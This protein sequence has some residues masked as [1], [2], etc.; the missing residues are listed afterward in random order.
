MATKSTTRGS[1][2]PQ[3]TAMQHLPRKD[4][5]RMAF[6]LLSHSSLKALFGTQVIDEYRL[7]RVALTSTTKNTTKLF[8][9]LAESVYYNKGARLCRQERWN[10]MTR[11][12]LE[13]EVL[14]K[15]MVDELEVENS[16]FRLRAMLAGAMLK[17][18]EEKRLENEGKLK[19]GVMLAGAISR[20]KNENSNKVFPQTPLSTSSFE[21]MSFLNILAEAK[22]NTPPIK[23]KSTPKPLTAPKPA[24][25]SIKVATSASTTS[26]SPKTFKPV[27]KKLASTST[28]IA[29]AKPDATDRT[30]SRVTNPV[31]ERSPIG[32]Q[33]ANTPVN[34]TA[35]VT[36]PFPTRQPNSRR[37]N[38]IKDKATLCHPRKDPINPQKDMNKT[39]A[40]ALAPQPKLKAHGSA[41]RAC[42]AAA[43][44]QTCTQQPSRRR[45]C[46]YYQP[47]APVV[48]KQGRQL[49]RYE[50]PMPF[51]R[52]SERKPKRCLIKA[53]YE[54][55]RC[56]NLIDEAK[57]RDLELVS[58]ERSYLADVLLI[59]DEAYAELMAK[60]GNKQEAIE[61]AQG[62]VAY[63]NQ[64]LRRKRAV[65]GAEK[66]QVMRESNGKQQQV[67]AD[68]EQTA[69]EKVEEQKPTVEAQEQEKI[70]ESQDSDNG[71]GLNNLPAAG[72]SSAGKQLKGNKR[73]RP[74]DDGHEK[75][76]PKKKAR[77]SAPKSTTKNDTPVAKD[78][79]PVKMM[80]L[81]RVAKAN[82]PPTALPRAMQTHMNKTP[83]VKRE[84]TKMTD[85]EEPTI[86]EPVKGVAVKIKRKKESAP[87]P[88][89]LTR[90]TRSDSDD[91]EMEEDSDEDYFVV[92]D[93][94]YKSKRKSKVSA[95]ARSNF[96]SGMR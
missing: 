49:T 29:Q 27:P 36:R 41:R 1:P 76:V 39:I 37:G 31:V 73:A 71:S 25:V 32:K 20:E 13:N 89:R 83:S 85:S 10:E 15:G 45:H 81:S 26:K 11:L 44:H 14:K 33:R 35:S 54:T 8:L 79:K 93:L 53:E 28:Y 42:E 62:E 40:G 38:Q 22:G 61:Y 4:I 5:I 16:E 47:S 91:E 24:P 86:A 3:L 87:K 12:Q 51:V 30:I 90:R 43:Q 66:E 74:S 70:R 23:F 50:V 56:A 55:M 77:S 80:K 63:Y 2:C 18:R 60:L 68:A 58:Q 34:G 9:R 94:A 7:K 72:D 67:R 46:N 57:F 88:S 78:E 17:E 96:F 75:S 59:D 82:G 6:R 64:E 65:A 19:P 69:S 48:P 52:K 92:D 95:M 84:D 21:E